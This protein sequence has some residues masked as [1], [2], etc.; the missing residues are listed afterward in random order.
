MKIKGILSVIFLVVGIVFIPSLVFAGSGGEGLTLQDALQKAY[1]QNPEIAAFE[2]RASAEEAL[3]PSRYSLSNPKVGLMHENLMNLMQVQM[4]PMTSFSVSQELLF[5]TKYFTQG[6]AQKAK[7]KASHH[8]FLEKKLEVRQRVLSSYFGV[9]AADRILALLEAQKETLREIARIAEAR[10]A[11]GGV[12][13]QDEM[14]AHVEQTRLENEILLQ[15]QEIVDLRAQLN[16][17]LNLDP[18]ENIILPKQDIKAPRFTKSA[19]E[20]QQLALKGSKVI[21]GMHDSLEAAKNEKSLAQQSYLPDFM[22]SYRKPFTNTPSGAFAAGV[23]LSIPLWFLTKQRSEVSAASFKAQEAEK[24]LELA[25]RTTQAESKSIASKVETYTNLIKVYE[26]ALIP[27]AA[28]TLNSSRAAYAAGR[29]GFQELLDSERSL[30]SIRI[31]Y[32]R[33]LAKFVENLT[34][35]ERISGTSLSSLPFDGEII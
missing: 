13:Q 21:A 27:Q 4:G 35:L 20:T 24:N 32:Y 18:S 6:A 12:P 23:E 33:T 11:T 2:A 9:Y 22:F 26:T 8:E 10:R 3:I 5:P 28:T 16:A 7:S 34:Q 14:K 31:D 30:Y 1:S 19:E 17:L 25:T 29:V 15:K